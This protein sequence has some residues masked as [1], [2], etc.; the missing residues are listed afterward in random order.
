[1]LDKHL[2][3]QMIHIGQ[4]E[5]R[6]LKPPTRTRRRH[7]IASPT[8]GSLL[9][10]HPDFLQKPSRSPPPEPID[11]QA[12]HEAYQFL[13]G[14]F[15]DPLIAVSE[16]KT[17]DKDKEFDLDKSPGRDK[18]KIRQKSLGTLESLEEKNESNAEDTL[19]DALDINEPGE[20]LVRQFHHT[21]TSLYSDIQVQFDKQL[22]DLLKVF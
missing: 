15:V 2:Q 3:D 11:L 9:S 18:T 1:M 8:T 10:P 13:T 6:T 7:S 22:G 5:D 12:V 4:Q 16:N 14:K 21:G 19:L 20:K 17:V